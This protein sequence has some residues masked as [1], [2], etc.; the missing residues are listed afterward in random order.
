MNKLIL[1]KLLHSYK[2]L[3]PNAETPTTE[4]IDGELCKSYKKA[5]R[6][7]INNFRLPLHLTYASQDPFVLHSWFKGLSKHIQESAKF[8]V[9]LKGESLTEEEA[10]KIARE[11][12]YVLP[13]E[14]TFVQFDTE[15]VI[16]NMMII[17]D[18]DTDVHELDG[19]ITKGMYRAVMLPFNRLQNCFV[20]DP[21]I[22]TFKFHDDGSYTFWLD[23]DS[24]TNP[25]ADII[26]TSADENGMYTNKSLNAWA[27]SASELLITFFTMLHY[28]QITSTKSVK[29]VKPQH[30]ES[31]SRFKTSELRGKPTWEHKTLVLDLYGNQ[32]NNNSTSGGKRSSGT[33]FHSVRKHLR[34]L[35]DGKHTFVKAH[36]RGSKDV[37]VVQKDYQIR[38]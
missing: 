32:D 20:Y 33:A 27:Q 13:Y 25:F 31:R 35:P 17:E 6:F 4:Y 26:D 7:F 10:A 16:I 21:N 14:S 19:T 15:D 23:E 11:V 38:T 22:Y 12:I 2:G 5:N 24:S 1:E 9:D 18:M 37:G 30:L 3:D 29:G 28:P 34:R 36:F 8:Y